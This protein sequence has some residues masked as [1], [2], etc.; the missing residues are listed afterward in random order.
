MSQQR[1][2]YYWLCPSSDSQPQ[3]T[4]RDSIKRLFL[5]DD[6]DDEDEEEEDDD[7]DHDEEE[8]G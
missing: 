8:E 1:A 7:D 4:S 3:C 6:D 5:D 2:L